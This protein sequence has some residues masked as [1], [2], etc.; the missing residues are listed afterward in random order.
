[1]SS[2]SP[3]R[4]GILEAVCLVAGACVFFLPFAYVLPAPSSE[5]MNG[6]ANL[7]TG[8][9]LAFVVEAAWATSQMREADDYEERLGAF[10]GLALAG[11]IGVVVALLISA[12]RAAGHANLLDA[13]GLAWIAVSVGILGGVVVV[14]PI[15]VHEWTPKTA[16]KED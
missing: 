14:Q 2:L 4:K 5:L 6:V 10:V 9:L 1:M 8:L 12:H 11:L 15:L 3:I 7:G 16:T 13:A